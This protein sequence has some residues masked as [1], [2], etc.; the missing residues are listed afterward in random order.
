[1]EEPAAD[2]PFQIGE[3][4]AQR[5]LRKMQ[6]VGGRRDAAG[7]RDGDNQAQIP[8]LDM[9][10]SHSPVIEFRHERSVDNSLDRF[11]RARVDWSRT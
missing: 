6:R 5:R 8:H 7:V 4:M 1:M 2:S 10:G 3:M 9:Q 11:N